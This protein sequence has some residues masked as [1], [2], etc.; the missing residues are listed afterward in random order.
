M[1]DLHLFDPARA[2]YRWEAF[3]RTAGAFGG[4]YAE[5]FPFPPDGL[6]VVLSSNSERGETGAMWM[7]L[8]RSIYRLA[9]MSGKAPSETLLATHRLLARDAPGVRDS[10]ACLRVDFSARRVTCARAGDVHVF[11]ARGAGGIAELPGSDIPLGSEGAEEALHDREASWT[12]GDLLL[13]AGAGAARMANSRG[14]AFGLGPLATAIN[15]APRTAK[16]G[17]AWVA[18][19]I[20]RHAGDAA[21]MHDVSL[22]AV[23]LR[24]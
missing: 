3:S 20:D 17:V 24:R 8:T 4:D 5:A 10:A 12:P 7:M 19:R 16:E 15:E 18:D 1:P 6:V 14:E 9:A 2:P 13:L 11:H 21:R 22:L 23:E